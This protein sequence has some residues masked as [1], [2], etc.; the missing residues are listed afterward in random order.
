LPAP[1]LLDFSC[2][3]ILNN[4]LLGSGSSARVYEGR[5]VG[6]QCAV[7]M[8]FTGEISREEI[9]RLCLE[10]TLLHKLQSQSEHVVQIFGVA[11]KPPSLC[12]VL[13]LCSEGSLSDVLYNEAGGD[14]KS[15]ASMSTP[16]SWLVG[17]PSGLVLIPSSEH[18]KRGVIPEKK[19]VHQLSWRHSLEL[20]YGACKGIEAI[21]ETLPGFSHN[22]IKSLNFLVCRG[23]SSPDRPSVVLEYVVKIG[24]VEFTSKGE[25]PPHLLRK[26]T[27]IIWTAPEVFSGA[28]PVS[29]AS[30]VYSL[31]CVL[32]EIFSRQYPFHD[33]EDQS[34]LAA[35]IQEGRRPLFPTLPPSVL[36]GN[37]S[38]ISFDDLISYEHYKMLVSKAWDHDAS[39]RPTA[40]ELA[41]EMQKMLERC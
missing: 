26:D 36:V 39:S 13:E 32:F 3:K 20:A 21:G 6:K 24:D 11:I 9:N 16:I 1:M 25:T 30:D 2:V 12:V 19:F 10:A 14:I 28:A 17:R 7:K 18:G 34:S 22:D 31:A 15:S 37:A 40:A 4:R 29:P 41:H 27:T 33:V 38:C 35:R 5:W 8:L 23:R